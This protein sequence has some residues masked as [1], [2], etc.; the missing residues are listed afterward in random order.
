LKPIGLI[1]FDLDGTLV[2]TLE[3]ITTS[4]NYTLACLDRQPLEL[5][6]V[7]QYV[8]DGL[9]RLIERSLGGPSD[10][11]DEAVRIYKEHHRGNFTN[12]SALYPSVKETLEYFKNIPLAV[13]TNKNTE[14]CDALLEKLSIRRYFKMTIGADAGLA[15]KPSPDALSRV[16]AEC[17]VPKELVLMVGDSVADVQAGKA[18]GIATC[19]VT[20]GYR[21]EEQLRLAGPDYVI[22]AI[23]EL[24]TLFS[25]LLRKAV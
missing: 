12:Q 1:L 7:R 15:L 17:G 13:I 18:A 4:L 24:K 9:S 20:Y 5:G 25:P 14:F 23:S 2:N 16:I 19:A 8:G 22:H 10:R 6:V 3:D 21:S 11:I